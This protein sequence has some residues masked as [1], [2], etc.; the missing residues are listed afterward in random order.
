MG[1][2]RSQTTPS[3]HRALLAFGDVL[4]A[5]LSLHSMCRTVK[6]KASRAVIVHLTAPITGA[7][8]ALGFDPKLP[9]TAA[10]CF[11]RRRYLPSPSTVLHK[12]YFDCWSLSLKDKM[13]RFLK[14]QKLEVHR[15]CEGIEP[16]ISATPGSIPSS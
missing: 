12:P 1:S 5:L 7:F 15:P 10:H 9:Q 14:E 13:V 11:I 8:A 2:S 6:F 3:R 4:G 16:L